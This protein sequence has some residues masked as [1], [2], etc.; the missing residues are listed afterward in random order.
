MAGILFIAF[1]L[2][3]S[4]FSEQC[5]GVLARR[6]LADRVWFYQFLSLFVGLAFIAFGAAMVWGLI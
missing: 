1:G 3:A 5:G 2:C 6:H 4:I